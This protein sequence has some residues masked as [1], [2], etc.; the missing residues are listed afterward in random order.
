MFHKHGQPNNH[1]TQVQDHVH[2]CKEEQGPE[3]IGTSSC[4]GDAQ[5]AQC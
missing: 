1:A 4:L 2:S 3:A 5:Y